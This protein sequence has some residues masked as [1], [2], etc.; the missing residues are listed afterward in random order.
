[1]CG[2]WLKGQGMFSPNRGT[3]R[4]PVV[5]HCMVGTW[6]ELRFPADRQWQ[7]QMGPR[8][9]ASSSWELLPSAGAA[10]KGP[11]AELGWSPLERLWEGFFSDHPSRGWM[12][13]P[14]GSFQLWDSA[15]LISVTHSCF[16]LKREAHVC[17]G[18][19]SLLLFLASS[20]TII[21]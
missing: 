19:L 10:W 11:K 15:H 7:G 3:L 8:G 14:P 20:L 12:R 17:S 2:K 13:S 21:Y 4:G 1:M 6:W 5:Q 18:C 9:M 16:W